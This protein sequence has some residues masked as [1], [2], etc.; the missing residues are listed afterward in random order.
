MFYILYWQN[1]FVSLAVWMPDS[2]PNYQQ[3]QYSDLDLC[4]QPETLTFAAARTKWT[5]YLKWVQSRHQHFNGSGSF[6]AGHSV[7]FKSFNFENV[8][9]D[10][11]ISQ[12][13]AIYFKRAQKK[14]PNSFHEVSSWVIESISIDLFYPCFWWEDISVMVTRCWKF[15][16]FRIIF[17]LFIRV[18]T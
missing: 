13:V 9:K 11:Y 17:I 4:L 10:L 1:T 18:N 5:A 16:L 7:Y 15:I 14:I 2:R 3:Q 6:L 12:K 8:T